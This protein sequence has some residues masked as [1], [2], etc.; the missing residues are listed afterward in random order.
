M[1]DL[2]LKP[3]ISKL[4]ISKDEFRFWGDE[5][6]ITSNSTKID[7][8]NVYNWYNYICTTEE[9]K[10]FVLDYLNSKNAKK[11]V[12]LVEQ[13]DPLKLR[14]I[15]WNLRIKYRGCE[16][17]KWAEDST[18]ESLQ[19]LTKEQEQKNKCPKVEDPNRSVVS[20]QDRINIKLA[21]IIG[22]FEHQLDIFADAGETEFVPST[23]IKANEIKPMIAKRIAAYY[24][25]LYSEIE[26][27]LSGKDVDLKQAY[28]AWEKPKVKKYLEFIGDIIAAGNTTV[29]KRRMTKK[30]AK[31]SKKKKTTK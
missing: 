31:A 25:P 17:P 10:Q 6:D 27:V 15:G 2:K 14:H 13:I 18:F 9:S 12:K 26:G 22:D 3:P 29:V 30:E 28:R 1:S 7:M 11:L 5:P 24:E 16:L 21:E 19:K 8:I 20:I 4:K 23:Y